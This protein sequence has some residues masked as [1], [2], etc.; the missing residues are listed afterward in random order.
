MNLRKPNV[1]KNPSKILLLSYLRLKMNMRPAF[2]QVQNI[3]DVLI[4]I[5]F[6]FS[7]PR[8]FLNSFPVC[9]PGM[10]RPAADG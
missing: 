10:A 8:S 1:F 4:T 2:R 9:L 5:G 7:A 6:T 3:V